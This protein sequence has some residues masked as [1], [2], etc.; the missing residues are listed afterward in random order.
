MQ[1]TAVLVDLK[2]RMNERDAEWAKCLEQHWQCT[3]FSGI[4]SQLL[5]AAAQVGSMLQQENM[6]LSSQQRGAILT[7]EATC[8]GDALGEYLSYFYCSLHSRNHMV[9]PFYPHKNPVM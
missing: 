1:K 8:G 3:P 7:E 9:P 4:L 2:S 6:H 5:P